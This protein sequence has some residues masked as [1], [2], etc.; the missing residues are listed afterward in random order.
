MKNRIFWRYFLQNKSIVYQDNEHIDINN[1]YI[2][3]KYRELTYRQ[4]LYWNSVIQ[5]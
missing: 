2:I 3:L 4:V 5:N 1:T